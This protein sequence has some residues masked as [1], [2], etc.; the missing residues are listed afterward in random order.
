MMRKLSAVSITGSFSRRSASLASLHTQNQHQQKEK[1]GPTAAAVTT[2]EIERW[3]TDGL[4]GS[5]KKAPAVAT[6]G[7][8]TYPAPLPPLPSSY[9]DPDPHRARTRPQSGRPRTATTTTTATTATATTGTTASTSEPERDSSDGL[10]MARHRHPATPTAATTDTAATAAT[11]RTLPRRASAPD[12]L[13][14]CAEEE[15]R[16]EQEGG[17]QGKAQIVAGRE[18]AK[19]DSPRPSLQRSH[20]SEI[21]ASGREAELKLL[22]GG[23]GRSGRGRRW[24][25]GKGGGGEGEGPG[26]KGGNNGGGG[27][28]VQVPMGNDGVVV[29]ETSSRSKSLRLSGKRLAQ[30]GVRR[31]EAVADGFRSLFRQG[32]C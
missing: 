15:G 23:V 25:G 8:L 10:E 32:G 2:V 22:G 4:R 12:E 21:S 19:N 18:S 14:R 31:R 16:G 3:A 11:A 30:A 24:K 29:G 26:E 9:P 7:D 5:S 20:M 1:T 13:G 17:E 6:P 28:G 27:G